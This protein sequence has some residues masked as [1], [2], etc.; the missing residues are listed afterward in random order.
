MLPRK[1]PPP[2]PLGGWSR[3]FGGLFQT[4]EAEVEADSDVLVL[5][6]G[7]ETIVAVAAASMGDGSKSNDLA[8]A[9]LIVCGGLMNELEDA[10]EE[11]E[12]EP[13]NSGTLGAG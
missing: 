4:T 3:D 12:V 7:L 9:P 8:L 13:A 6:A 1:I 11:A 10:E 5:R 2:P